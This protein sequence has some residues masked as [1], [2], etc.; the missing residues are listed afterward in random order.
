MSVSSRI[1]RPAGAGG[2]HAPRWLGAAALTVLVHGAAVWTVL[3]WRSA[4]VVAPSE[5]PPAVMIDLSPIVSSPKTP[6]QDMA[7][8]PQMVEAQPAP[9]DEAAAKTVLAA[10]PD[11]GPQPPRDEPAIEP[12]PPPPTIERNPRT[13]RPTP[14]SAPADADLALPPAPSL[15]AEVPPPAP[16]ELRAPQ[17]P[18]D[19]SAPSEPAPPPRIAQPHEAKRSLA[20]PPRARSPRL[21]RQRTKAQSKRAERTQAAKPDD[22]PEA[23]RTRMPATSEATAARAAASHASSSGATA[24]PALATWKGELVAHINRFKRF[25][26]NAVS[27]GTASVAF[28][29]NRS[30]AVVS[31]RLIS[32]SGDRALD[33]EAVAL[34]HRASPVPAP[35]P[36][37]SAAVITSTVPI[38]FDR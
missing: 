28:A 3:H 1:D 31:A 22:R 25:P 11:P 6:R 18:S 37:T 14:P 34:L 9:S 27:T 24:S 38:R 13:P 33:E 2:G 21:D 5:P 10:A 17:P 23:D 4:E 16:V 36:Q 32:S 19:V 12:A 8:G 35:P 15:E 30:G 20:P 26:P 29:I 7:V